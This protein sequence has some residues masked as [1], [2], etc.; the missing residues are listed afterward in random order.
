MGEVTAESITCKKRN[1]ISLKTRTNNHI[2]DI[3]KNGK[4]KKNKAM[5]EN[6]DLTKILKNCP[7]GTKLFST[8]AGY[9]KFSKISTDECFPIVVISKLGQQFYTKD[10]YA[11]TKEYR[12]DFAE[13][14]LFPAHDQRDWSKFKIPKPRVKVTLHPFDKVLA[15]SLQSDTWVVDI[16]SHYDSDNILPIWCIGGSFRGEV[17]PYNK[18][19]AHLLGTSD[20]PEIE[21]EIEFSKEFKE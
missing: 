20:K 3:S 4:L 13:L 9:V 18:D 15:W 1:T 19:T 7:V 6:L 14:C 12:D 11:F 10:G 5:N 21:Y 17:I 2:A 16:F 8:E